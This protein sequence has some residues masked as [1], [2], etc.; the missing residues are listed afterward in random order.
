MPSSPIIAHSGGFPVSARRPNV[1]SPIAISRL[2]A[3]MTRCGGNLSA[4]TPPMS[5]NTSDGAIWAAST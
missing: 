3:T 1:P 5:A 4:A 2:A